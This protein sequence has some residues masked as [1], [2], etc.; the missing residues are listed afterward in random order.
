MEMNGIRKTTLS[1]APARCENLDLTGPGFAI[2][3][4][5]PS[6]ITS[7]RNDNA[8][9]LRNALDA[10]YIAALGPGALLAI[11]PTKRIL[12]PVGRIVLSLFAADDLAVRFIKYGNSKCV[13]RTAAFTFRSIISQFSSKEDC[14][15]SPAEPNPALFIK[16]FNYYKRI[17]VKIML[18]RKNKKK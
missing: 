7:R 6:P 14:L 12:D 4:I 11:D 17:E 15:K 16:T 3:T 9:V 8:K 13:K 10:E 18:M 1:V 5:T 2:E